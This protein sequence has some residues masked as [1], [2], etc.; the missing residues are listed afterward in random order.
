M[1]RSYEP[2]MGYS[3]ATRVDGRI[4]T[5]IIPRYMTTPRKSTLPEITHLQF[6]VLDAL[7]PGETSGRQIRKRI[8]ERRRIRK[9]GPAFYQL[10]AR[11]EDAKLVKGW[12]RDKII[13]DYPIKERVYRITAPGIRAL[14]SARD[15]YGIDDE[16]GELGHATA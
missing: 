7:K 1:P 3:R 2:E 13:E 12:Y 6:A 14:Q 8:I 15:F 11:L 5:P 9:S 16:E 10:M 4:S